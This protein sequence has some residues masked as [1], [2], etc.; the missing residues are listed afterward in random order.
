MSV[1]EYTSLREIKKYLD[2][3]RLRNGSSGNRGPFL[4]HGAHPQRLR[5]K[6]NA[7]DVLA[8]VEFLEQR[9]V[10]GTP[11]EVPT[12]AFDELKVALEGLSSERRAIER[13]GTL[14]DR[15]QFLVTDGEGRRQ[16]ANEPTSCASSEF[17][18]RHAASEARLARA[19]RPQARGADRGR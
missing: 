6:Y 19:S 8:A 13:M 2:L 15:I 3:N 9:A 11:I 14:L 4:E 7:K 10:P 1:P 18:A 16:M 12:Q 5:H 17:Y